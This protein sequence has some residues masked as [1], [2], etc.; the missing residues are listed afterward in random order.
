MNVSDKPA[1]SIF[2]VEMDG[3]QDYISKLQRKRLL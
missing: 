3:V 2:S 1:A